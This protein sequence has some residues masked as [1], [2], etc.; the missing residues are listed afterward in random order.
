MPKPHFC[1]RL[2]NVAYKRVTMRTALNTDCEFGVQ[3]AARYGMGRCAMGNNSPE[4][5]RIRD[6]NRT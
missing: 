5:M 6:D 3:A 4:A 2:V 1:R